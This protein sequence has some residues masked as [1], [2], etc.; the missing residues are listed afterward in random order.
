M[1]EEK[2]KPVL[3]EHTLGKLL[4]AA[5][6]LQ[7]HNRELRELELGLDLK[8]DQ[9]EARS[10]SASTVEVHSGAIEAEPARPR[11][12]EPAAPADYTFTLA[13]IVATQ[14]QIQIRN[15]ELEKAIALVTG[16]VTEIARA[17]GAAIGILEGNKVRYRAVS[18]SMTL[19]LGTEVRTEKALCLPCIR[20]AQVF[21]CADV[22]PEFLVD[23]EECRRRGIQSLIAV[24]IF[25]EGVAAGG[26][27]LYYAA[28]HGF[29]E[30]DVHTCQLMA[31][32]VTEA[33][34][35]E[36]EHTWKQSLAN[37]RAAMLE[38]I[39]K[40][41]PNLSALAEQAP[42][43]EGPAKT[44]PAAASQA[45]A[46]ACTHCG[47]TF[48]AGEQFCG[49]CGS[50]RGAPSMQ[51]KVAS[52]L[53]MQEPAKIEIAAEAAH[54]T[55]VLELPPQTIPFA[56]PAQSLATLEAQMPELFTPYESHN[57]SAHASAEPQPPAESA[58]GTN[59]EIEIAE[60]AESEEPANDDLALANVPASGDWSSAASAREFLEQIA[61][62]KPRGALA[63]FWDARR[64]DIYLAVAV[65]L[66]ACV[67]RW[68][69]WS[70]HPVS[71]T[72]SSNLPTATAPGRR[73]P[74]PIDPTANL[75]LFDRMLISLGLADTPE[76]PEDK[77]DPSIQVW[78]DL[79]T[80]LYYCPGADLYG[81]TARGKYAAQR[82]AQLDEYQP[83]Y[84]KPCN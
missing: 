31:G 29:T 63:G 62:D 44:A 12:P 42:K 15:L 2:K 49:Q 7:E 52:L 67:I 66:V 50:P 3:D 81:K 61:E 77:G 74:A 46:V 58:H 22:N 40:L 35:R 53:R 76:V 39:E 17:G 48:S 28:P 56:P 25:H 51:S 82:D 45:Q 9:I 5:Y 43:T 41:K 83:A 38:A 65:V 64:G 10:E 71:A 59:R 13:Q 79:H 55:P 37:E 78:V 75:S 80:A 70:N 18:G 20:N 4:E 36:E 26:L 19:K 27:E 68:G 8:R 69:I 16:R 54:A 84:R 33:L 57:E 73:R 11:P 6:V 60:A 14:H 23:S 1:S 21:R 30:Q 72:N 34:A 47:N 32:L 24:P